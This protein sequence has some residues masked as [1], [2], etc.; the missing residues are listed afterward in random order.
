MPPTVPEIV[1]AAA[2][3][4]S[5]DAATIVV[6]MGGSGRTNDDIVQMD[7]GAALGE[8]AGALLRRF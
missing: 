5:N 2:A 6:I 3:V 7:I 1:N 4:P 8:S